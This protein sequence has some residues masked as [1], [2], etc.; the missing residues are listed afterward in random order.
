MLTT[1]SSRIRKQRKSSSVFKRALLL[2]IIVRSKEM[3]IYKNYLKHG[4]RFYTVSLLD[5]TWYIEYV[6]SNRSKC[7]ILGPITIQLE[8]LSSIYTRL[9]AKLKNAF[10][11]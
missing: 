4:L 7:N 1:M 10:E 5:S 6:R 2:K 8:A 9:E 11:K 3:P